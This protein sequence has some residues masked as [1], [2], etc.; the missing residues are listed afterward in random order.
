MNRFLFT[1]L[2]VL[3]FGGIKLALAQVYPMESPFLLFFAAVGISAWYG[4]SLQGIFGY[5]LSVGFM[6]LF[7]LP[8]LET[9]KLF[10]GMWIYRMVLYGIDCFIVIAVFAKLRSSRD[11]LEQTVRDLTLAEKILGENKSTAEKLR[12]SQSFL[13]SV[14]ENIPNMIFVKDAVN[15]RFIRFNKAGE[16]LIGEPSSKLIGK[17]D[18][19]FF[20]KEEADFFTKMDR[21]VLSTGV[22]VDIPEETLQSRNGVRYLHTKK[23]PIFDKSGNPQYL[24]GIS[25]DITE[26]KKAEQQKLMLLDQIAARSEAE[27]TAARFRFLASATAALSDSF[28][29]E[30]MLNSFC[31][32]TVENFSDCCAIQFVNEDSLAVEPMVLSLNTELMNGNTKRE[33]RD[34]RKK[35]EKFAKDQVSVK[36]IQNNALLLDIEKRNELG[37]RSGLAV[38]LSTFGKIFGYMVFLNFK[39]SKNLR[40]FSS[41]DVSMAEDLG[42]RVSL[43]IENAK[44][45]SRAND[46]SRAK[47]AFLANMSHEIRTPLGAILGYAELTLEGSTRKIQKNHLQTIIRN[48]NQLLHIVDEILDLS[49]VESEKIGIEKLNFSLPRLVE[50]VVG[51]LS[52]KAK[53]KGIQLKMNLSDNLPNRVLSDPTRLRQILINIIGNAIKFTEV[54]SVTVD[55]R[56]KPIRVGSKRYNLVV[57]VID[58]GIGIAPSQQSILFKPFVQADGS[59]TR[60]FGGTGLGLHLSR[61]L[62]RLLGGD[63]VLK[64]SGSEKGSH[65]VVSVEV[66]LAG[67]VGNDLLSAEQPVLDDKQQSIPIANAKILVVDDSIDNRTLVTHFLKKMGLKFE[68]ANN[69]SEGVA[70]ALDEKFDLVLMDLQMP[71]MDGFQAMQAL[72]KQDYQKPIVALTAHA[73]KGDR[74]RCLQAGFDD[75]LCKPLSKDS[76]IKSLAQNI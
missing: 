53:D 34:Y 73:M 48:G 70:K 74:E 59:M 46:A 10:E 11:A 66:E 3:T 21:E 75:Y 1:F 62:A 65:F 52:L 8:S 69:G 20:P 63:V 41:A 13:D 27:R 54:G 25:E 47:S 49:K 60:K 71:E 19:D 30:A 43:A 50:E 37:V 7:F 61:K 51:L 24:L 9:M 55:I 15:L 67:P 58:T 16:E 64:D 72:R 18:H 31:D 44:L 68:T 35:I 29:T 2:S 5:I 45:Y 33:V 40:V 39:N 4:G 32:V 57:D 22:A 56:S 17:S 6:V 28:D 12:Q 42:R 26:R 36:S 14:I 38:S 23:I 76:L